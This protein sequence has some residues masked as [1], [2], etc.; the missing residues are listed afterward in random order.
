MSR[1]T[2]IPNSGTANRL[3]DEHGGDL[4]AALEHACRSLDYLA[5][6]ASR[7]YMRALPVVPAIPGKARVEPLDV[8]TEQHPL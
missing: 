1:G 6:Q 4:A 8:S 3:L 5:S 2:I 7:G